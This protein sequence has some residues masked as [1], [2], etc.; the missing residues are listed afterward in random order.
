MQ[1]NLSPSRRRQI[2]LS[3]KFVFFLL[4]LFELQVSGNVLSQNI[5]CSFKNTPLKQVF[6]DIRKQSGYVFFYPAGTLDKTMPITVNIKNADIGQV[7]DICL[8]DQPLTYKIEDK[9]VL[10]VPKMEQKAAQQQETLSG[11]LY[12]QQKLF[13][14]Q[15]SIHP[16]KL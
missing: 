7:L 12:L 13:T 11:N 8:K 9:T 16:E 15:L 1:K 6:K 2:V 10:I 14:V 4:F 5:N 3:M